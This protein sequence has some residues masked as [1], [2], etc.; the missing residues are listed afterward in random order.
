MLVMHTKGPNKIQHVP[1]ADMPQ[2]HNMDY[3]VLVHGLYETAVSQLTSLKSL[4]INHSLACYIEECEELLKE[5]AHHLDSRQDVM[6]N[7]RPLGSKQRP[8]CIGLVEARN[9]L[10]AL[11]SK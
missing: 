2:T 1:I 11:S 4:N 7:F 6:I 9:K 5:I 10:T 8:H 3:Y